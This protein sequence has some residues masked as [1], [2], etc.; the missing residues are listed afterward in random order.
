MEAVGSAAQTRQ[1]VR[2]IVATFV[3]ASSI[4]TSFGQEP[5]PAPSADSTVAASEP[6]IPSPDALVTVLRLLRANTEIHLRMLEPVASNTHRRG[7]RFKLEVAEVVE[8][9]G[10]IVIPA[11]TPAEGEVIHA[12]KATVTGRAGELIL[13][14]RFLNAGGQQVMLRAF[15]AGTGEDRADLALGLGVFGGI[16]ALFVTGKDVV[17]PAGADVFAKVR[18]DTSLRALLGVKPAQE[19]PT[20]IAV[21][22]DTENEPN[23]QDTEINNDEQR[24]Q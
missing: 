18:S 24:E 9:D 20:E 3:V 22:P 4:A 6:A 10:D 16:P 1:N 11:G 5:A 21:E 13:V 12:A 19:A 7:D 23:A 15:S 17:I 14:V 8:L 2:S